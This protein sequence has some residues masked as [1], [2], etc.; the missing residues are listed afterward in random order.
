MAFTYTRVH[1]HTEFANPYL[2]CDQCQAWV[3]AWHNREDCGCEATF[4]NVPCGHT[5]GATS[6]CPS[7]SPVDGCE[8]QA[9]LGRVPHA[10]PPR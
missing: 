5:A 2:C 8:C 3:T 7:W 1:V 4:W 9:H 6:A 10:E